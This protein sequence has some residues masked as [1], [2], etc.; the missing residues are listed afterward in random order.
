MTI[1]DLRQALKIS[2]AEP[3]LGGNL[4]PNRSDGH[5]PVRAVDEAGA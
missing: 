4:L 5:L 2:Q 3:S 1:G